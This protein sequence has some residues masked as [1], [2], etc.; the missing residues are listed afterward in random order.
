M[1]VGTTHTLNKHVETYLHVYLSS[2]QCIVTYATTGKWVWSSSRGV[3]WTS[4]RVDLVGNSN[5]QKRGRGL[6]IFNDML[7]IDTLSKKMQNINQNTVVFYVIIAVYLYRCRIDCKF[8]F[9]Y[10]LISHASMCSIINSC[11]HIL[12]IYCSIHTPDPNYICTWSGWAFHKSMY[13]CDIYSWDYTKH[14]IS[15]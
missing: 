9:V 3:P 2:R 8:V 1:H 11:S 4:F 14:F 7:C 12:Y 15:M 5:C 6:Y 10:K 13:F